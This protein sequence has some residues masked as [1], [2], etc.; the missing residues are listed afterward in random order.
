[1][2]TVIGDSLCKWVRGINFTDIQSI[3]GLTL[4]KVID[5]INDLTLTINKYQ[6]VVLMLGTNDIQRSMPL[7]I[8]HKLADVIDLIR[9]KNPTARIACNAIIPRPTDIPI[10][11]EEIRNRGA[12][13]SAASYMP[14][15][16][17]MAST[18]ENQPPVRPPTRQEVYN[19]LHPMEKKRRQTNIQIRRL[20]KSK[21]VYFLETWKAMEK[22]KKDRS[23]NLSLYADDGLHL[24]N[25][26]ISALGNYIE[27][28]TACLLDFKKLPKP[29]RWK[30]KF[31]LPIQSKYQSSHVM[32]K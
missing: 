4:T 18:S 31:G 29:K 12:S 23:I 9:E 25:H 2:A 13:K 20:C 6:L 7:G 16:P 32:N 24:N 28:T 3:P 11:M 19:A 15:P 30:R 8:A 1:M 27:G 10:H 5:R 21:G 26:G 17:P 22:S 14:P